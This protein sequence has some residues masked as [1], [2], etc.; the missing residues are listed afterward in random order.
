MRKAF[1]D[2]EKIEKAF[3]CRG[4]TIKNMILITKLQ[5]MSSLERKESRG[6]FYRTDYPEKQDNSWKKNI[7]IRQSGKESAMD[8]RDAL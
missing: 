6:V 3:L 5:L 2:I 8:I 7:Y 1:R 4:I